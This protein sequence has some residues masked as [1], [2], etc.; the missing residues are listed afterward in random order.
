MP[1]KKTCTRCNG[2]GYYEA[3]VSQ[4]DDE[5]EIVRCTKCNGGGSQYFMTDEEEADYYADYW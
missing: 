2:E 1:D 4:H 5:K 3:L